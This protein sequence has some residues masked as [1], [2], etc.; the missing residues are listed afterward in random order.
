MVQQVN[1]V[2]DGA[3]ASQP[4]CCISYCTEAVKKLLEVSGV[5]GRETVVQVLYSDNTSRYSTLRILPVDRM[6]LL[7][8]K[9]HATA[10]DV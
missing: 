9:M 8:A 1:L 2:L 4:L 3:C 7:V 6:A 5:S 10:L